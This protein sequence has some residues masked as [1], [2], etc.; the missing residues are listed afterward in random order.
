MC[1]D[2]VKKVSRTM[3]TYRYWSENGTLTHAFFC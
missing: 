2:V 3:R 1:D